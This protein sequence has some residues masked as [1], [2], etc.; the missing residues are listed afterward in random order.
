MVENHCTW[1]ILFTLSSTQLLKYSVWWNLH[2]CQIFNLPDKWNLTQKLTHLRLISG[3]AIAFV[4][5]VQ[6]DAFGAGWMTSGQRLVALVHVATLRCRAKRLIRHTFDHILADRPEYQCWVTV[7]ERYF[8]K[9]YR[10]LNFIWYYLVLPGKLSLFIL[11]YIKFRRTCNRD[12]K[13]F[14]F[15]LGSSKVCRRCLSNRSVPSADWSTAALKRSLLV[16]SIFSEVK[17]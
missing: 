13:W 10:L 11:F 3:E 16:S 6:V 9:D 17:Q 2:F 5:T 14:G 1:K 15:G 12:D 7:L 8:L 4:A